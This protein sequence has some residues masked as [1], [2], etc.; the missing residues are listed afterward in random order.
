METATAPDDEVKRD[1]P[2][3]PLTATELEGGLTLGNQNMIMPLGPDS[4]QPLP[5]VPHVEYRPQFDMVNQLSGGMISAIVVRSTSEEADGRTQWHIHHLGFHVVYILEGWILVDFEGIGPVRLE[6]GTL[7]YQPP[8]NRHRVLD[9]SADFEAL[10]LQ[11]PGRT[12]TTNLIFDTESESYQPVRMEELVSDELE[13]M[14][15]RSTE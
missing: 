15:A 7:L 12:P 5:G 9:T 2:L 6:K 3:P 14:M 10:D 1:H 13:G 11:L 4:Y 8:R